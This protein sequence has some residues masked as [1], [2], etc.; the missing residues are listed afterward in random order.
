MVGMLF[1]GVFASKAVNS[2][3]ADGLLYG[4]PAFFLTQVKGLF[5]AVGYSVGVSFL[6]FKLVNLVE[7]IRVSQE[8]EEMGLDASQHN[9]KYVQGTLLVPEPNGKFKEVVMAGNKM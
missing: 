4:N 5:V 3:G 6:I 9:E 2:A 1:A 7:P 8:E